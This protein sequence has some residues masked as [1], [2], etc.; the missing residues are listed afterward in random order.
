MSELKE[1]TLEI[2]RKLCDIEK[3]IVD[4]FVTVGQSLII[5]SEPL[6]DIEQDYGDLKRRY[7][8]LWHIAISEYGADPAIL[9]REVSD[10]VI[11]LPHRT[12]R[13]M[14]DL[15]SYCES[16]KYCICNPKRTVGSTANS[17]GG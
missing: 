12:G 14:P 15:H 11:G 17:K 6:T 1:A 13:L 8:A 10:R 16:G 4:G 7:D 9:I 5:G 2:R 3:A